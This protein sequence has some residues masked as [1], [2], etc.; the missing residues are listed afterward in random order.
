LLV[1]EPSFFQF[2]IQQGKLKKKYSFAPGFVL[3]WHLL[4]RITLEPQIED[5]HS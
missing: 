1:S 3:V 4:S 5:I 2:A